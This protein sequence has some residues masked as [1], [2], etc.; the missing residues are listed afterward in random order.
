VDVPEFADL[1]PT[2]ENIARVIWNMLEAPVKSLGVALAEVTV[3]ETTRTM[4]TY[5]GEG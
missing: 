4:C 2:V 1:N 5:R 3:W